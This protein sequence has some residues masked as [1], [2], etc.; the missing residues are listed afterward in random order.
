MG[1]SYSV[2]RTSGENMASGAHQ[3]PVC[4]VLGAWHGY[5]GTFFLED[6]RACGPGVPIGRRIGHLARLEFI[7]SGSY[8]LL[9]IRHIE[10]R[11][12]CETH[13]SPSSLVTSATN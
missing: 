5:P 12:I 10:H 1:K 8:Q 6:S 13:I 7:W 4:W 11:K 3:H 9:L 2:L